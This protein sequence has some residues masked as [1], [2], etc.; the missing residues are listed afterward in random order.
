M[1]NSTAQNAPD[2]GG[3]PATAKQSTTSDVIAVR[4]ADWAARH[5]FGNDLPL[6]AN[7]RKTIENALSEY[8]R[9]LKCDGNTIVLSH[10]R[11]GGNAIVLFLEPGKRFWRA[12]YKNLAASVDV[13]DAMLAELLNG[14]RNPH[15]GSAGRCWGLDAQ[16]R[17]LCTSRFR[18]CGI[19]RPLRGQTDRAFWPASFN[20]GPE[21]ST[22]I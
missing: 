7:L 13:P 15:L 17:R 10:T 4:V 14:V 2:C 22:A 19:N 8:F 16:S 20:D 18:P 11:P 9:F 6:L 3:L 12:A 21:R 1:M 5:G